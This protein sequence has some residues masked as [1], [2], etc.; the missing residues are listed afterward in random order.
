M[1]ATATLS[2]WT[3]PPKPIREVVVA[4]TLF[5]ISGR[6]VRSG[7]LAFAGSSR[8]HTDGSRFCLSA[9]TEGPGL[10]LWVMCIIAL[11]SGA[12]LLVGFLTPIAAT[13]SFLVI[14][15]VMFSWLPASSW[16]L[17]GVNLLS[18]NAVTMA[19]ATILLGP[20]AFSIDARLFGR[21]KII[22]PRFPD[23]A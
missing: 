6:L 18:F 14:T 21:R 9:S 22:I 12:S 4:Q 20:G 17:F 3:G 8:H 13:F 16:N 1:T 7:T 10:R 15:G 2:L 23:S 19:L 11:C 5:D